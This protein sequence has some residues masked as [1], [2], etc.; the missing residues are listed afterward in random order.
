MYYTVPLKLGSQT[1]ITSYTIK[2][3]ENCL[4]QYEVVRYVLGVKEKEH[5][6]GLMGAGSVLSF[7]LNNG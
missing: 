1:G 3:Q 4:P 5:E 2:S 7:N 6:K